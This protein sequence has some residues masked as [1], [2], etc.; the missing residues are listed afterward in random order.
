MYEMLVK[1]VLSNYM[2]ATYVSNYF[3]QLLVSRQFWGQYRLPH[4]NDVF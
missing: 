2:F 1:L 4:D 3:L